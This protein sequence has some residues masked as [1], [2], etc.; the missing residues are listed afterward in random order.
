ME[1]MESMRLCPSSFAAEVLGNNQVE[2]RPKD[3]FFRRGGWAGFWFCTSM[4]GRGGGSAYAWGRRGDLGGGEG[5]VGETAEIWRGWIC[6]SGA[7]WGRGMM[8]VVIVEPL[9][10]ATRLAND[11]WVMGVR[12]IGSKIY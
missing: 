5:M 2:T 12:G 1:S 10:A 9:V 7:V 8:V 3:F 4:R 11:G 6:F